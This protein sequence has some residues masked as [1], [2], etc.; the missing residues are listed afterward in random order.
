MSLHKRIKRSSFVAVTVLAFTLS[1]LILICPASQAKAVEPFGKLHLYGL[2]MFWHTEL[3]QMLGHA[4]AVGESGNIFQWDSKEWKEESSGCNKSLDGIKAFS[5]DNAWAVGEQ[6][7]VLRKTAQ[8]W[9]NVNIGAG[10]G[11]IDVD[12]GYANNKID[13]YIVGTGGSIYHH[14]GSHWNKMQPTTNNLFGVWYKSTESV[15][16]VGDKG[17]VQ[18][19]NGSSWNKVAVPTNEPLLSVSG[20]VDNDGHE[21]ILVVG[22]G[23][24]IL[25]YS[26]YKW[27]KEVYDPTHHHFIQGR[28]SSQAAD[29][30]NSVS[31]AGAGDAWVVGNGGTLLRYNGSGWS[32]GDSGTTE[33]LYCIDALDPNDVMAVGNG[34]AAVPV[35]SPPT[36]WYLAEGTTA[37]GFSAYISIENPNDQQCTA[38]VTYMPTGAANKSEDIA[39]PANSQTTITNDHLMDVLGGPVDFSTEINCKEG[40]YIAVDR[41]MSW[42][43]PGAA[44]PEAHSSVGVTSPSTTW[45]LP[46]GSSEWGFECWLLIQNPNDSE[47]TC[48]VTYMIENEGPREVE[49][50]VPANSRATFNMETDIGKKDASIKVESDQPVIPE[51]AM[52]RNDRREGHDS[53][54]TTS[55]ANDYYLAEGTTAWGFTTYI[56]VQNPQ[57]TPTDVTVTYM[58]PDGPKVQPAFEMPANSRKTIRVNDVP[59]V[60]STDLSTQV[61]GSQPIIAERAM[62]WDSGSGEACHDSI[63]MAE[64]HSTFYL[65]DGQTSGGRETWTLIQNPNTVDVEVE[66]SYLTPTGENNV[67]W[68]ETIKAESRKTF[69]M[70]DKGINGRAAVLVTSKTTGRKVMVE[71]AMYWNSR[72]AGTDTIGGYSDNMVR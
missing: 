13:L 26:H 62:Y 39:L 71:R 49:H 32:E 8:G 22:G 16:A 51:R 58:T 29:D 53:I 30:L 33:N 5:K 59:G 54:G 42:T 20:T 14:D 1:P 45:Y 10:E 12:G 69:N 63:G 66:I 64:P 27:T 17:D 57:D 61:S 43:G 65:P 46:E 56:L 67:T 23:G 36:T 70:T 19:Y 35:V 48:T 60:S 4:Y 24:N 31:F 37:W 6:G 68:K 3:G 41:T 50:K 9:N 40:K 2:S 52:Y 38:E 25:H 21:E 47:A 11:L 34:G 55:P 18:H 28:Q 72:G 7:T 44:S 15:W